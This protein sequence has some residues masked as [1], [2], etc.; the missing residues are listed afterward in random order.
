LTY[1]IG[2]NAV[3]L[4]CRESQITNIQTNGLSEGKTP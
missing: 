2:N 3:E 1:K 4:P